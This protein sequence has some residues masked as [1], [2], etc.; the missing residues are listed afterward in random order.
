MLT[1]HSI[2]GR[3]GPFDE[4]VI[5]STVE[6]L[7][8]QLAMVRRHC[9]PIGLEQLR[10]F[11][12]EGTQLPKNPVL[13][14]FDDGYRDNHE[15]ALPILLRHGIR[16]TFFIATSYITERRVF[17]WDRIAYL[18]SSSPES[19][20]KLSYPLPLDLDMRD[21]PRTIRLL[22]RIAKT[23]PCLDFAN[24]LDGIGQAA[25][26]DWGEREE[27][28]YADELILDWKQILELRRAGMDIASHTRTHRV[29]DTLSRED[30]DEELSGSREELESILKE[31]VCTISYPVGRTI[32][33]KAEVRNAIAKAGYELGFSN[34]SGVNNV[35]RSVDPFD[36][37]RISLDRG[38]DDCLFR[39]MLAIPSFA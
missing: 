2:R 22:Q 15:L 14:T 1:Y 16:A 38:T 6:Q 7:D 8:R 34:A 20:A 4:G 23:T 13:V 30:L 28:R 19:R 3:P 39:G 25:K 21:R 32:S 31:P 35:W 29:L 36:L 26:V 24:Y 11:L 5:D 17:W 37:R 12:R 33:D 10:A 27:R 18:I 9:S